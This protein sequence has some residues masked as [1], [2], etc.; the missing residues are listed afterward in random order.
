MIHYDFKKATTLPEGVDNLYSIITMLRSPEGCPWDK[1]QTNKSATESLIDETYEYLDGV[2]K[3]DIASEREEIGDI[4][5][6]V[7]MNLYIHEEN[8]DF[9]PVD[10]LNEVCE[11]LI[12]RHPHVFSNKKA[13]N[14]DEVLSLW[15]SVKENVEGKKIDSKTIFG[16]IPTSLPPLESSY[17]IQKKLKKVGFD[18]QDV[19]GIYDKIEEEMQEVKDAIKSGSQDEIESEIGD[20]LFSVV[21]LSR[22]LRIRPNIALH[23]TNEKVKKRFTKLFELAEERGIAVSSEHVKEMNEIWDEI[24]GKE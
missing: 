9:K 10:A 3:K 12:R 17:E 22:F 8:N 18:W 24:K 4:M 2:I 1:V 20:L 15:N 7:F 21:N 19:S 11:K 6:N 5:I 13:E 16:H 14:S 23:R